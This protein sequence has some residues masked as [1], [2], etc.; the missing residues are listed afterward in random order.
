M[1]LYSLST[2]EGLNF[3]ELGEDLGT[4]AGTTPFCLSPKELPGHRRDKPA[5]TSATATYIHVYLSKEV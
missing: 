5:G 1:V 4:R 3:R 2:I